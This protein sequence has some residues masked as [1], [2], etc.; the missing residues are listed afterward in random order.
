[1]KS[2]FSN[3]AILLLIGMI[4]GAC[5]EQNVTVDNEED[6]DDDVEVVDSFHDHAYLSGT[7]VGAE[8]LEEVQEK[9]QDGTFV[10]TSED[11]FVEA[12]V[13][14]T[15]ENMGTLEYRVSGA[16]EWKEAELTFEA[17]RFYNAQIVVENTASTIELRGFGDASYLRVEMMPEIDGEAHRDEADIDTMIGELRVP[18]PWSMPSSVQQAGEEQHVRYDGATQCTGS[19]T[20][21]ASQLGQFV[22]DHFDGVQAIQ[23]YNCRTIGGSNNLSL[24]A[25]GRAIDIMLPLDGSWNDDDAAANALGDPIANWLV[26]NAEYIGVQ[27][28]IWDR[29]IW[30]GSRSGT[31]HRSYGGVHPHHD[32]LHVEVNYDGADRNTQFFVDGMP[33]PGD[34]PGTE[35]PGG[36]TPT[37]D[38]GAGGSVFDDFPTSATGYDEAVKLLNAGITEGCAD[39]MFCPNCPLTRRQM[40]TFLVRAANL[41]TSNPPSQPSFSDVSTSSSSYAYVEAAVEAGITAGC[42]DGKFCPNEEITRAQAATMI[43]RALNWPDEVPTTAPSFDDVSQDSVHFEAV[44][45]LKQRCVTQGCGDGSEFCGDDNLS[46]AH[47]AVFISRAFNLE[48]SNACAQPGGCEPAPLFGTDDSVFSDFPT[49]QLGYEETELLYN[50]GITNGCTETEFCPD[51]PTHRRAMVIFLVRALDIDTSN[52]PSTATFDDVQPSMF[53]FPE[54]EAAHAAGIINGCSEDEFCPNNEVSRAQAASMISRAMSWE[55][56]SPSTPTFDDV[57]TSHSHYEGIETLVD[58]CVTQGCG[59]GSGFCPDGYIPRSHASIFLARALNLDGINPC[60]ETGGG[61]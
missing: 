22:G 48:D 23:G 61:G 10:A 4:L 21:G 15:S 52:P 25:T 8:T 54:I 24:H 40:A 33:A 34:V 28:I 20:P 60:A 6:T 56:V 49:D 9:T 36:C 46:R 41:D 11:G 12:M 5:G 58:R 51:C 55:Q 43:H 30:N 13:I 50:E 29:V 2:R 3:I 16:E 39:S 37:P 19:M 38:D 18:G 44:E 59:D 42:G 7:I 17:G 31:K 1:M 57:S 26:E 47:A 27:L 35:E 53:G 45:T 14:V 32:H